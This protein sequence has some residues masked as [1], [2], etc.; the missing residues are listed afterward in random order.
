MKN[1]LIYF[2]VLIIGIASVS[3]GDL[4]EEL[5]YIEISVINGTTEDVTIYYNYG[6]LGVRITVGTI[7]KNDFPRLIK[8]AKGRTYYAEG[9][10]SKRNYGSK[11]IFTSSSISYDVWYI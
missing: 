5:E 11:Y 7:K 6:I 9:N 1:K 4:T 3:C 8:I 10:D 2:V